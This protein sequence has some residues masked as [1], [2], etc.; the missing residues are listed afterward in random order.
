MYKQLTIV[1]CLA[2]EEAQAVEVEDGQTKQQVLVEEEEDHAGDTGIGPTAVHQQQ[3]LQESELG[4]AEVAAHHSLH[5][6]LTT[7]AHPCTFGG[8]TPLGCNTCHVLLEL[9]CSSICLAVPEQA[10]L[11]RH[12]QHNMV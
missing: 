10:T 9:S 11:A 7:D 1:Q 3:R 5:A 6:L 8:V 12:H 4:D 2:A